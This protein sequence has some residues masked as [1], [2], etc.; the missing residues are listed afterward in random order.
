MIKGRISVLK[1][2]Q[3]EISRMKCRDRKNLGRG[4]EHLRTVKT[5]LEVEGSN[6]RLKHSRNR[7]ENADDQLF[8]AI[9]L[10]SDRNYTQ[11]RSSP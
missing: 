9:L 10:Y 11:A 3:Y 8:G 5:V 7:P 1:M 6:R 2:G 4:T